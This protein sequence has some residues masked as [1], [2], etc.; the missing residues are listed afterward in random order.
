MFNWLAF[1]GLTRFI[2][3]IYPFICQNVTSD[4]HSKFHNFS[5]WVHQHANRSATEPPDIIIIII[6]RLFLTRRNTTDITRARVNHTV[7]DCRTVSA[8]VSIQSRAVKQVSLQCDFEGVYRLEGADVMQHRQRPRATFPSDSDR[9]CR[10]REWWTGRSSRRIYSAAIGRWKSRTWAAA[11]VVCCG[12]R[13]TWRCRAAGS[14]L[15]E[16]TLA[17]EI[18]ERSADRT[19]RSSTVCLRLPAW[20]PQALDLSRPGPAAWARQRVTSSRRGANWRRLTGWSRL[21]DKSSRMTGR[22]W[23]DMRR[24]RANMTAS[25]AELATERRYL[26]L[27]GNA[28]P[29]RSW[30]SVPVG[31]FH[32]FSSVLQIT[33]STRP[34]C[35]RLDWCW[36][37]GS[38]LALDIQL[39]EGGLQR[40]TPNRGLARNC[41]PNGLTGRWVMHK[42]EV[43]A[44][45]PL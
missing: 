12:G 35:T 13:P 24:G 45:C 22:T 34:T 14:G 23:L 19:E 11:V 31:K 27:D 37:H 41:I 30:Q 7:D 10:C 40:M 26:T 32:R 8:A 43:A 5:A 2:Y 29:S 3:F 6:V 33:G 20:Q 4:I 36:L 18:V 21:Y 42:S 38:R 44:W 9:E 28:F 1:D 16:T 39:A 25:I 15:V 17:V